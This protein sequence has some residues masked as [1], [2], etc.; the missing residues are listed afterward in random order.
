MTDRVSPEVPPE[1][2][3]IVLKRSHQTSDPFP[4]FPSPSVPQLPQ[5]HFQVMPFVWH[6]DQSQFPHIAVFI[7]CAKPSLE[8]ERC[9]SPPRSSTFCGLYCYSGLWSPAHPFS[10]RLPW[11][12]PYIPISIYARVTGLCPGSKHKLLSETSMRWN[13]QSA[14]R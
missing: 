5:H 9:Q 14:A 3:V 4:H 7:T 12:V 13:T 11:H 2:G 6:M 1:F 8:E 10:L